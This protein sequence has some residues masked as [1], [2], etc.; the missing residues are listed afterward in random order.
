VIGVPFNQDTR[1]GETRCAQCGKHNPPWGH[2]NTFTEARLRE[3]FRG[4][5][6]QETSFVGSTRERTN[7][8]S[9]WMMRLAGNPYGMY[10]QEEPCIFCGHALVAPSSRTLLSRVLTAGAVR[11]TRVQ[12]RFT[13]P[14]PIWIQLLIEKA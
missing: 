14:A 9:A 1:V 11:L 12:Q 4:G 5:R 7:S 10:D 8:L 2:I 6:I 3:L 13:T